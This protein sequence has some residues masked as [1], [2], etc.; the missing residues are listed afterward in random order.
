MIYRLYLDTSVLGALFD[1]EDPG[2]VRVTQRLL[3]LLR[4]GRFEP[5]VG[6]EVLVEIG[7][8]PTRLRD[9]LMRAIE[10]IGPTTLE[11]SAASEALVE[12]YLATGSFRSRSLMDARHLAVATVG[13]VDA[14]VSWNYRD[15]VNLERKRLVHSVNIR[16]GYHMIDIVSPLEVPGVQ[17]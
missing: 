10:E 5:F 3:G 14:L 9:H 15:M 6:Q 11:P 8:A 13:G 17:E 16:L 2:R 7:Q 1:E 4:E 12:A